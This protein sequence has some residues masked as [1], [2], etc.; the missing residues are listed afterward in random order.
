[1]CR[2]PFSIDAPSCLLAPVQAVEEK[3][4][5]C[6]SLPGQVSPSRLGM[7]RGKFKKEEEKEA[8]DH[9]LCMTHQTLE[10]V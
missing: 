4:L 7:D 10:K 8:M 3:G 2:F 5:D 6:S 9:S 1:M